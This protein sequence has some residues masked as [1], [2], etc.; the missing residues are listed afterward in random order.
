MVLTKYV[1]NDLCAL[2]GWSVVMKTK[3]FHCV[4]NTAMD[5][6]HTVAYIRKCTAYNNRHGIV[7]VCTLDFLINRH[8]DERST[9]RCFYLV[10]HLCSLHNF[11]KNNQT[12]RF[13]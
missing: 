5:W 11:L 10:I 3:F 4:E 12:S 7:Y 1:S 13:A 8:S 9:F 2:T 6:F